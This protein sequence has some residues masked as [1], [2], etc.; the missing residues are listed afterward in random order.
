VPHRGLVSVIL[1]VFGAVFFFLY[2]VL[3]GS[4]H[5]S[6]N[7]GATAPSSVHIT[8][9]KVYEISTP[10]GVVG[11]Q[12]RGLDP[13][14]ISCSYTEIGGGQPTA[15]TIVSLGADTRT[16]HA[17]STFVAPVTGDVHLDCS[18][19]TGGVFVDDADNAAGDPAGLFLLLATIAAALAVPLGMSF[20]YARS[21]ARSRDHQQIETVVEPVGP[22]DEIG[23]PD[24]GDIG[25]QPG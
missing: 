24:R 21:V 20:L 14:S 4:E 11:L 19:L 10:G 6:F 17:V 22:D 12:H 1:L 5:H 3:N 13:N 2:L 18:E 16:T 7:T 23:D 9:G 15:L 25:G 8:E